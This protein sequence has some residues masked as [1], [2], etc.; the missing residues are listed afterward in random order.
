MNEHIHVSIEDSNK[1]RKELLNLNVS[2]LN[3]LARMERVK[4]LRASKEMQASKARLL[5]KR[6]EKNMS[7]FNSLLPHTHE[8]ASP[9]FSRKK[10]HIKK[11][12]ATPK[13]KYILKEQKESEHEHHYSKLEE[14]LKK[15]KEKIEKL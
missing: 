14:E 3:I 7:E 9:K 1:H 2:L 12:S 6:L 5:L 4:S 10:T 11:I 13:E 8:P 15:L